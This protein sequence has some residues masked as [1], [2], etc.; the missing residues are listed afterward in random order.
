[1]TRIKNILCEKRACISSCTCSRRSRCPKCTRSRHSHCPTC[2][3]RGDHAAQNAL[4]CGTHTAP[5]ALLAALTLPDM[6][7]LAALTLPHMHC[8]RH[9]CHTDTPVLHR[10]SKHTLRNETG[11]PNATSFLADTQHPSQLAA[12]PKSHSFHSS[13]TSLDMVLHGPDQQ[14]KQ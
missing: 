11:G 8:S 6:H 3:A 14:C 5:H 13:P 4:A 10:W 9:S 7:S 2:T 1:M 12:S